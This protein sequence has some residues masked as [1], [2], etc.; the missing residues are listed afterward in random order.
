MGKAF[1]PSNPDNP[2][3]AGD[4]KGLSMLIKSVTTT[5][6][7]IP[8]TTIPLLPKVTAAPLDLLLKNPTSIR[9]RLRLF[10]IIIPSFPPTHIHIHHL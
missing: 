8:T 10:P 2:G 5:T 4:L 3:P 1:L 7:P 9:L 6:T